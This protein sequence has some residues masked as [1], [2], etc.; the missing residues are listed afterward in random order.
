MKRERNLSILLSITAVI[1]LSITAMWGL[2]AVPTVQAQVQ[3]NTFSGQATGLQSNVSVFN[4]PVDNPPIAQ[5]NPLP[6][7]GGFSLPPPPNQPFNVRVV[8]GSL[9]FW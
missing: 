9:S 7:G 6:S 1:L 2:S 4:M 8:S 3:Q 5:T